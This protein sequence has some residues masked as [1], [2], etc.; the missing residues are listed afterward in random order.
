[1][2]QTMKNNNNPLRFYV[3]AYIREKDSKIAK[4]G[5][6]YYNSGLSEKLYVFSL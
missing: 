4:A 1:M 3:Y 6:P 5:T 2:R